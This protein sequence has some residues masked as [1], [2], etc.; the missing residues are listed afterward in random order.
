MPSWLYPCW[1]RP[2]PF[3]ASRFWASSRKRAASAFGV[4][5]YGPWNS[6]YPPL[7]DTSRVENSPGEDYSCASTHSHLVPP[8]SASSPDLKLP[9]P[10][11]PSK[12]SLD[13]ALAS[14]P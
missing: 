5:H 7:C 3:V 1:F 12:R 10:H 8:S 2:L 9:T 4:K 11:R 13:P 14:P 6:A